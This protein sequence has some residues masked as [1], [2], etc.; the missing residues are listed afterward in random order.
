[1]RLHT[2]SSITVL[3]AY[4]YRLKPTDMQIG[5]LY[6]MVGCGR[7]VF[8]RS[9]ESLLEI[10]SRELGFAGSRKELYGVLNTLPPRD[11]IALARAFPSS[12]ALNKRLTQWKKTPAL[13][14]LTEAYTD[15]LQQ[16]QRDLR[17]RAIKDWC[18]GKRGF[19]KFRTRKLAHHSTL[20][21][22]NF[23]KYCRLEGRH[24]KLPNGLGLVRYY[25][26]Q[27]VH[28]QPR[29]CTVTLDACGNWSVSVLCEVVIEPARRGTGAVGIDMGIAKNMTLSN[30]VAYE[31]VKSFAACRDKVA[32]EQRKLSRKVRGSSN[33]KKQKLK[34]A[35]AYKRTAD[36]RYDY[37][38]KKTTEI[39]NTHAMVAVEALKVANMSRSTKGT[40]EN[41]GS[42]VRQKS[43]LN[44]SILDEGWGDIRRQLEYK[45]ARNGGLF[46]AVPPHHTSQTCP[47]CHHVD[48]ENRKTQDSFTCV[49]CG[50]SENAD[51]VAAIN[52]LAR[53]METLKAA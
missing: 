15:N 40:V 30:G 41:P 6:R 31:G 2:E 16:R 10:A 3:K 46:I 34:V 21:F 37:Q 35:R 8:N 24:F 1:M 49:H 39:S 33:W 36:M 42:K 26:S 12:A 7:V 4:K 13:S 19:P 44:R 51:V 50:F 14:F 28:G 23:P 48:A 18:S 9:L 52:V 45:M 11:R 47:A 32:K 29:S 17:D 43:G 25:K 22:V 53:G 27:P 38:Q 5:L 20:R